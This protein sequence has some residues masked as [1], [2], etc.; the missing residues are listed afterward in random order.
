MKVFVTGAT[1]YIGSVV[2]ER[3]IAAG[4]TVRGLARSDAAADRLRTAGAEPV[5]GDLSTGPLPLDA[6]RESDGVISLAQPSDPEIRKKWQL[7]QMMSLAKTKK[8]F[9]VTSGVWVH[10]DSGGTALDESTPLRPTR[11]VEWLV[12]LEDQVR[13]FDQDVRGVVIRPAVVY[14]RGGGSPARMVK[15]AREKGVVRY[16]GTGENRW[17]F[18]HVEDLA[19]LYLLALERAPAGSAWI[20]SHGPAFRVREVAE[21]ASRGAGAGGK[22]QAWPLAEAR[23]KLGDYADALVLDQIASGK[24]AKDALGWRPNRP[25]VIEDLER[26]SY[27]A[28]PA[29]S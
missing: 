18:V 10:G 20:A 2:V 17:P 28:T 5:H 16:V 9:V 27:V 23:Q 15:E 3:L 11:L 14:G 22:T 4:H 1:G 13:K 7:I 19:D 25:D 6:A 26:G 21:A 24:H 12:G 8:P 29:S